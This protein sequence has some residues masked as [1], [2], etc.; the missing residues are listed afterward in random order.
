MERPLSV[1]REEFVDEL[2]GLINR[3]GLEGVPM[4]VILDVLKGATQEVKEAANK[5][6]EQDKLEYEK[7]KEEKKEDESSH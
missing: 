5:Q 2:V 1:A 3:F 6:Y 4:F 7:T